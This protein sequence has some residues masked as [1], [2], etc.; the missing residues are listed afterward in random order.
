MMPLVTTVFTVLM[1]PADERDQNAATDCK[2]LQRGYFLFLSTI[3]SNECINVFK[4]LGTEG[5]I[6][7]SN[8]SLKKWVICFEFWWLIILPFIHKKHEEIIF[9]NKAFYN[10][11][12]LFREQ[13]L[14]HIF[15][16]FIKLFLNNEKL[17]YFNCQPVVNQLI[18]D[19]FLYSCLEL[20]II[21][22]CFR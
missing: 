4:T 6:Q 2:L 12:N 16:F 11:C 7:Q 17:K 21:K 15:N 8:N 1:S 3:V 18:F 14:F 10:K 13:I 20:F 22:F 19:S 5:S 9:I